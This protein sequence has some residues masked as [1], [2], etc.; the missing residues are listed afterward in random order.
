[1]RNLG[2]SWSSWISLPL[3]IRLTPVLSCV[4]W[5]SLLESTVA[6]WIGSG[7]TWQ[8]GPSSWGSVINNRLQLPSSL[9]YRRVP[10]LGLSCLAFMWHRSPMWS[11]HSASI[12]SSTRT[13]HNCT[14]RSMTTTQSPF[15]N[16]AWRQSTIGSDVMAWLWT[17]PRQ[18]LSSL[19]PALACDR[20]P[21]SILSVWP[22]PTSRSPKEWRVWGSPSTAL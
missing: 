4:D 16:S 7:L 3:S 6:R 10:F 14:S 8:R 5:S 1:M 19:A 20:M 18:R 22:E 21:P 2:A 11:H 15:F 9:G 13:T 17:Q 12:I